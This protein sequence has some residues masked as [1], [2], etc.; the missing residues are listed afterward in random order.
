LPTRELFWHESGLRMRDPYGAP[1]FTEI[2]L[3]EGGS[4]EQRLGAGSQLG[5]YFEA[6]RVVIRESAGSRALS[7]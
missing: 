1:S 3:T 2:D 7:S 5:S 6:T 4:L